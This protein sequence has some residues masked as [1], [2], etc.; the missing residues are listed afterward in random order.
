MADRLRRR[1]PR[2]VL[3]IRREDVG[4]FR[5]KPWE[6]RCSAY[7]YLQ[8]Q[9]LFVKGVNAEEVIRGKDKRI[10]EA[11]FL[12]ILAGDGSGSRINWLKRTPKW[13]NTLVNGAVG[14]YVFGKRWVG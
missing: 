1:P 7:E 8:G 2:I 6:T 11:H 9:G 14:R 4:K 5:Q 10:Q 13:R 12:N 3:G